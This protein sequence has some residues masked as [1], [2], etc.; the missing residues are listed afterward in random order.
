MTEAARAEGTIYDLGYQRYKGQRLGRGNAIRTL[1]GYSFRTAFGLGRGERA[2]LG[3]FAIVL[4]CFMPA[5]VRVG[6]A[7]ATGQTVLINYAQHLEFTALWLALYTATQAPEL[8]VTDRQFGTLA[9][10]LSRPLRA[11]DYMIAKFCALT[12]ALLILTLGPQLFLFSGTLL[13]AEELFPAFRAEWRT[14]LPIAGG[15]TGASLLFAS[16]GLALSS[17]ASKRNYANAAV[18]GFFLLTSAIVAMFYSITSGDLKRY[19]VLAHPVWVMNGFV[20]WL[21]DVE[22]RRRSVVGRADLPGEYY[23]YVIL[24]VC[25]IAMTALFLQYR[26]RDE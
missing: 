19:V 12:A 5:V 3:P 8:I 16:I 23:L 25:A 11:T 21:F 20:N 10:Y 1:F 22:A 18:I 2:K 9:L 14:L 17:L 15:S 7:M 26:K 13:I 6:V 4:F 24:G